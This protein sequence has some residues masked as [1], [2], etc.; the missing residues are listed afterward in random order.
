MA[1]IKNKEAGIPAASLFKIKISYQGKLVT[2][3]SR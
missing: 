3:P 1:V 2:W